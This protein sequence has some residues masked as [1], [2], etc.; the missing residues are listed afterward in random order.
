MALQ[1]YFIGFSTQTSA[2]TGNRTLYDIDLI[3]ADLMTSFQTR[4]GE[5]L[6]RPDWGCRL[7][8]YLF[9]PL[10]PVMREAII[11]EATRICNLDSRTIMVNTQV[12]EQ[13]QGFRI[14]IDL[15]YLPWRVAGTFTATF[16]REEQLYFGT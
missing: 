8:Q 1:R 5:R 11:A 4:V 14:S 16:Q 2:E 3:N 12:Y 6:M 9:E 7:W 13:D 15:L 10:T